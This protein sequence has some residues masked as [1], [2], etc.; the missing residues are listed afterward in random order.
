MSR[1]PS[2]LLQYVIRPALGTLGLPGGVAAEMLVMGTAA[3]ESG[4]EWLH[5]AGSGPALSMWQIEPATARDAV[6]RASNQAFDRLAALRI[7]ND[8]VPVYESVVDQL[9]GNLYLGAAMCRLIYYLKPF[10]LPTRNPHPVELAYFWKRWYNTPKGAGTAE[11]FVAN[12]Q[13]FGLGG[14]W[15]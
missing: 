13:R 11:E 5:Q 15:P 1:F 4:F 8:A 6:L 9:P 7:P 2:Q 3:Q 14:L 12:W 10:E